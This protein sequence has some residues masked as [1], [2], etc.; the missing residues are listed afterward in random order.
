MRPRRPPAGPVETGN[1]R[2]RAP[3]GRP[4]EEGPGPGR[5]V[6]PG[7]APARDVQGVPGA[8]DE[9]DTR[10]V[11]L[12]EVT[13]DGAPRGAEGV[14]GPDVGRRPYTDPT[15]PT[16]PRPDVSVASSTPGTFPEP[17]TG[18]RRGKNTISTVP[19]N[20]N[21]GPVLLS[22]VLCPLRRRPPTS[23]K[24]LHPRLSVKCQVRRTTAVL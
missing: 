13:P 12:V 5:G 10:R 23:F 14:V 16:P 17:G 18:R 19:V 21:R 9:D 4:V 8:L 24:S 1:P 3:D 2:V 15:V 22:G 6:E 11:D 7:E 20:V